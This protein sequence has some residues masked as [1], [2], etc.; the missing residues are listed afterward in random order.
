MLNSR[1]ELMPVLVGCGVCA[2]FI[3]CDVFIGPE[4]MDEVRELFKDE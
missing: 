2:I 1:R 3:D 4:N